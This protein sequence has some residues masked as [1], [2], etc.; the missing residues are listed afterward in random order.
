MTFK[1]AGVA[2]YILTWRDCD[3]S[4]SCAF[5]ISAWF[6]P[7]EKRRQG[8]CQPQLVSTLV[9]KGAPLLLDPGDPMLLPGPGLPPT[10][11]SSGRA[12]DTRVTVDQKGDP[13]KQADWQ[14]LL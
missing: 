10:M 4:S 6:F 1:K 2:E 3:P 11:R 7:K 5:Q 13:Q 9:S 14:V 8:E 12:E